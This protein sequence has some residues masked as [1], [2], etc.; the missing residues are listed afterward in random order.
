MNK[1][2][3][4]WQIANGDTPDNIRN[5]PELKGLTIPRTGRPGWPGILVTKT[6]LIVGEPGYGPTPSAQRGSMLRAYNKATGAEV[7]AVFMPAPQ[8]GS[9]MTYMQDGKQY[10][11]LAIS[12]AGFPAELIAFK[13][14]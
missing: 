13:L 6:L 12:G 9:P 5:H 3:V 14:P 8:T 4:L 7:G 10:V 11:V 2:D 1:G